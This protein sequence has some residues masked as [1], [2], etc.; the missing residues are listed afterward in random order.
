MNVHLIRLA[1]HILLILI[2]L[3]LLIRSN[4]K[5]NRK[6]NKYYIAG[7]FFTVAFILLELFY[8]K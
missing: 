4:K 8:F 5:G 3:I 7:L 1:P 6:T 2:I